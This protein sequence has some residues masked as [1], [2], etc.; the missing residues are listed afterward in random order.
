MTAQNQQLDLAQYQQRYRIIASVRFM[1]VCILIVSASALAGLS[2]GFV[3]M[4]PAMMLGLFVRDESIRACLALLVGWFTGTAVV[5]VNSLLWAQVPPIS[6]LFNMIGLFVFAYWIAQCMRVRWHDVAF[7]LSAA[8]GILTGVFGDVG[9]AEEGVTAASGWLSELPL[10]TLIFC[11][12]VMAL[13]PFPKRQDFSDLI[14]AIRGEC[15]N[16]LRMM[17]DQIAANA[18]IES[19]PERLNLKSFSDV[20]HLLDLNAGKFAN[21]MEERERITA[22]LSQLSDIFTDVRYIQCTLEN[23]PG[24]GFDETVRDALATVMAGLADEIEQINTLDLEPSFAL[25]GEAEKHLLTLARD[26]GDSPETLNLQRLSVR[27]AGFVIAAK[28]L[29]DR[30]STDQSSSASKTA[31]SREVP[32]QDGWFMHDS[33]KA[34][35]KLVIGVLLG[36]TLVVAT[37]VPA[38]TYLVFTILIILSQPNLGRAHNRVRLWFPGVIIGSIWALLGVVTLSSLPYFGL[39]LL[40]FLPGLF[41]AGYLGFGPDRTSFMGMQVVCGMSAIMGLAIFPSETVLFAESRTLSAV[42]GALVALSVYHSLWPIHPAL[43]LRDSLAQRLR[44]MARFVERLGSIGSQEETLTALK[45]LDPELEQLRA[46]IQ[47]DIGLLDDFGSMMSKTVKPAYDYPVMLREV[48][49]MSLQLWCLLQAS[50]LR[51]T[52]LE[53]QA[54]LQPLALISIELSEVLCW[55]AAQME[56]SATPQRQEL[57]AMVNPLHLRLRDTRMSIQYGESPAEKEV[58]DYAINSIAVMLIHLTHLADAMT[59][60]LRPDT[61]QQ[62]NDSPLEPAKI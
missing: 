10:G 34:A 14:N 33:L 16:S 6:L 51:R 12:F 56:S 9:G 25:L 54:G 11:I 35:L 39:Y 22:Q 4:V 37:D 53:A 38:N 19:V 46:Q 3:S 45:D 61:E 60:S 20:E 32:T 21:H 40:W 44:T 24:Q 17:G 2:L 48:G 13:W 50:Q 47:A 57:Q 42:L 43:Q 29:S 23:L 58:S 49:L 52:D 5:W 31:P 28:A 18:A 30:L 62:G 8:L 55:I 26:G 7:P 59:S 15:A 41:L 36:L 1:I 27:I